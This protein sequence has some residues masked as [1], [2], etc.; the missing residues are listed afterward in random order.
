MN[1]TAKQQNQLNQL[2]TASVEKL[3][4]NISQLSEERTSPDVATD[5]KKTSIP[6][7]NSTANNNMKSLA[8][9]EAQNLNEMNL[10]INA[11]R[12]QFP[13]VSLHICSRNDAKASELLDKF[14][15]ENSINTW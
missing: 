13:N 8:F 6:V 1:V 4:K 10:V 11:I 7:S 9:I 15:N 5:T 2:I 14:M 3:V 12:T